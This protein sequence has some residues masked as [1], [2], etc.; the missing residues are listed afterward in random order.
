MKRVWI[1][2]GAIL[3]APA[4]AVIWV[5]GD[6]SCNYNTIQAALNDLATGVDTRVN[7]ANNIAGGVYFENLNLNVNIAASLLTIHGGYNT[8]QGSLTDN[9][10][11]VDGSASGPVFNLSGDASEQNVQISRMVLRNGTSDVSDRAGGLN[12]ADPDMRVFISDVVISNNTGVDGGGLNVA[13]AALEVSLAR[14][15]IVNN[16]AKNGGGM[17]CGDVNNVRLTNDSGI[18]FN[19]ASS[20][21]PDGGRGGGVFAGAGCFFIHNAGD[22]L[23]VAPLSGLVG[24]QSSENGG[25]AYISDGARYFLARNVATPQE[26]PTIRDNIAE[27]DGGGAFIQGSGSELNMLG[28]VV[29]GNEA[30]HGGALALDDSGR[31]FITAQADGTCWNRQR[32]NLFNNNRAGR[33]IED[34][35]GGTFYLTNNATMTAVRSWVSESQADVASVIDVRNG[36][37]ASFFSSVIAGNGVNGESGFNNLALGAAVFEGRLSFN[38]ATVVDNSLQ[39]GSAMLVAAFSA[40]LIVDRSIVMDA[41]VNVLDVINGAGDPVG[42]FFRCGLVHEN[43]SLASASLVSNYFVTANPGFVD[44]GNGDY[45]I[46]AG[47]DA[48]DMCSTPSDL[49]PDFEGQP[50]GFDDP[51]LGNIDGAVDAGA[52]ESYLADVIFYSGF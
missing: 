13:G 52:D 4:H 30:A 41:A 2:L 14:T 22:H 35:R 9:P 48:V 36:A 26:V 17:H 18:S 51:T 43:S 6:G 39:S 19:Q 27:G 25:G 31:A 7:I 16:S 47:A 44:P 11:L 49:W 50:R 37:V 33:D 23:G 32:C 42:A 40:T 10:T 12:I 15:L 3:S 24:N 20:A 8:C 38:N 45:R 5:G 46:L 34:G 28:G 21:L 29:D 1:I